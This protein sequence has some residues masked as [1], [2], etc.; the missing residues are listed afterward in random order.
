[1]VRRDDLADGAAL[2]D[3]ADL[4]RLGVGLGG[5]HPAAH[6]GVEREP[7]DPEQDLAGAGL[8][9]G[10]GFEAEMVR[11]SARLPG[12]RRERSDDIWAVPWKPPNR[13][14]TDTFA[15]LGSGAELSL[16]D[17]MELGPMNRRLPWSQSPAKAEAVMRRSEQGSFTG[18]WRTMASG[19][20]FML[21]AAPPAVP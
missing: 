17:T 19:F 2:H 6:V 15:V 13:Q 14:P 3:L 21:S 16:D 1:M 18:C 7:E 11:A 12:E 5:A 20:V 4:D 9:N 8:R 10:C